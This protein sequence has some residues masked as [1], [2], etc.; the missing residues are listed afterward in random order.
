MSL[1][2]CTIFFFL[3]LTLPGKTQIP[4]LLRVTS[5]EQSDSTG[6]NFVKEVC[7]I[8]YEAIVSGKVKLWDSQAKD[9]Q[10]YPSGLIEIEKSTNTSFIDLEVVFIYEYWTNSN[11]D[12][13]STTTG[14]LFSNKTSS[15]EEVTYGYIDYNDLQ[16]TFMRSRI[17][18][19]ANGNYNSTLAYYINNKNYNYKILQFAGKVIDNVGS[20]QMIK[21]DFIGTNKFNSSS[22]LSNDIPQKIVTWILDPSNDLVADKAEA[23]KSLLSAIME[24]LKQNEEILYNLGGDRIKPN[25]QNNKLTITKL[26]VVE[27]WKKIDK[28]VLFDP[29]GIKIYLNDSALT[30]IKYIDMLKMD[31]KIGSTSWVDFIREK[32]FQYNITQINYQIISRREAFQ[33]QKG[34]L[35][36]DWSKITDFVKYY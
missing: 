11:R 16:E 36:Y 29:I 12:L 13:K 30:E 4:V 3:F 24:F 32:N 28:K 34:L 14:F 8:A 21:D 17:Q 5:S 20:S 6:C 15:G 33:Y 19:N 35:T 7:R 27:L 26:Q 31:I 2:I 25:L 1:K 10:I 9:I 22:F 18:M 23:G